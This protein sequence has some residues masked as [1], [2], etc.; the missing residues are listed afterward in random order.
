MSSRLPCCR[1]FKVARKKRV[2][3]EEPQR[4]G[5]QAAN[6]SL[7]GRSLGQT[8]PNPPTDL[9]HQ[10]CRQAAAGRPAQTARKGKGQP[11][12]T[13]PKVGQAAGTNGVEAALTTRSGCLSRNDPSLQ[14]PTKLKGATSWDSSR[15]TLRRCRTS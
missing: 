6:G 7:V 11:V 10:P 12:R 14:F 3:R 15:R 2:G 8:D 13:F 4:V 9:L 5:N 1:G